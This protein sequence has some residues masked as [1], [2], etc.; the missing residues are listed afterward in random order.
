MR[1]HVTTN[2][3]Q[4]VTDIYAGMLTP[5]NLG[6][7]GNRK[8]GNPEETRETLETGNR[9]TGKKKKEGGIVKHIEV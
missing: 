3:D 7:L 6:N 4:F 2:L 1:T 9:E 5:G 8:P